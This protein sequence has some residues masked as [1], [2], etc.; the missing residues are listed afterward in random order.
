MMS[1]L[2]LNVDCLIVIFNYFSI[3]EL[4]ELE[5]VCRLFKSTCDTVYTTRRFHK[6]RIELRNL[7][8]EYFTKIFE[9]VGRTLRNFEFSGGFIM[10]E[11]VKQTMIDGVSKFCPQLTSLTVNYTS[12]TTAN[13]IGLQDSFAQLVYLDLSRC[14]ID[15]D[16]LQVSLDGERFRNVKTLKLAGNASMKGS[17]FKSMSHVEV[18]DVS[19]CFD[20]EFDEFF[21]FLKNCIKLIELNVSASCRMVHGVENFLLIV[22]TH[23]PQI[24]TLL[25]ENTGIAV[26]TSVLS[27]FERLRVCRF[28]GRRFGI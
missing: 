15:E 27:K 13:F 25:M 1:I 16:S 22:Y 20:L 26:D 24:E 7:R 23:Q 8:T 3:Y 17:F 19:Y 5:K 14:G 10:N 12:F 28:E 2:D 11:N 6:L 21:H 18:L 9:R 4:I